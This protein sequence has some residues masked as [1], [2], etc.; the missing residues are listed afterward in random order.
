MQ[1]R[2]FFT[3]GLP[4]CL[5]FQAGPP[6]MG[7]GGVG[8]TAHFLLVCVYAEVAACL[9]SVH[10]AAHMQ[11][12][13]SPAFSATTSPPIQAPPF[14]TCCQAGNKFEGIFSL[15]MDSGH[16]LQQRSLFIEEEGTR[17]GSKCRRS[18]EWGRLVAHPPPP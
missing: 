6:V 4:R 18:L 7:G 14:W 15:N 3:P 10:R 5:Y 16:C 2:E 8:E 11:P 13:A 12:K 17:P 1:L 9:C